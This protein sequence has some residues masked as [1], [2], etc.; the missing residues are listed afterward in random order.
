MV[1]VLVVGT[2]VV[3]LDVVVVGM[4]LGQIEEGVHGT[5]GVQGYGFTPIVPM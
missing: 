3:V 4:Q 1:V 2:A 5:D